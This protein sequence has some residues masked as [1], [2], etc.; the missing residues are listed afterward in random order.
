MG[1][2]SGKNPRQY[3]KHLKETLKQAYDSAKV[4]MEKAA[5]RNKVRYD[6][7][8]HA[9]ELEEGDRCLVWKVGGR[10]KSKVDDRWEPQVYRIISKRDGV[11]V[12]AVLPEDLF[13]C[14]IA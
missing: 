6:S 13:V 3:V 10:I 4:G 8:A 7:R 11:P 12:Y 5:N 2:K 9:A 1:G 14:F